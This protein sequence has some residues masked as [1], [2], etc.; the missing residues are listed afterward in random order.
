MSKGYVILAGNPLEFQ[1][2]SACAYSIM[3]ANRDQSVS[4]IVPNLSKVPEE[5]LEPF[6]NLI[7]LPF[8]K[9]DPVRQNDWQLYWTTP[10]DN[11]IAIDCKC[12]VKENHDVLWDYLIDHYDI[13]FPTQT[14]N[15]DGL[16]TQKSKTQVYR[17]DYNLTALDSHMFFFKKDRELA[18]QYFKMAD[19][20][21][22]NWQTVFAKHFA[23]HHIPL[24]YD[25]NLIHSLIAECIGAEMSVHHP[26]IFAY[27]DMK[28]AHLDGMIGRWDK[29][30]DRLDAWNSK[31][32]KIKIQNFA[33][34][35]TVYYA[36][37]DFFT[38][39]IFN[40]QRNYY[41][42]VTK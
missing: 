9:F 15:F 38:E 19:P 20:Y 30:T 33:V 35:R 23:P 13:C 6:E 10:Y 41:R 7:E 14:H 8:D 25:S 24:T 22:R 4:L 11:T 17:D 2:A 32:G 21:M 39:E 29:W 16:R 37:D 26:E 1:Q 40:E 36:E 5:L 27:L 12:L 31:D 18:L 28:T 3:S 42:T 34:N